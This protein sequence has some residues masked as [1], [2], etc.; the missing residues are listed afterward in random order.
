VARNL[1]LLR[2]WVADTPDDADAW[3]YLGAEYQMAGQ[4]GEAR[5]AYETGLA[6]AA[7][8]VET[9]LL[10][11]NLL[12]VLESLGQWDAV[13]E[14]AVSWQGDG[15]FYPDFWLIAGRAAMRTGRLSLAQE[16]FRRAAAFRPDRPLAFETA[17][18]R[19]WK[20][21]AYQAL[22]AAETGDWAFVRQALAPWRDVVGG[23][24]FLMRLYLHAGLAGPSAAEVVGELAVW[25]DKPL[26]VAVLDAVDEVLMRFPAIRQALVPA[27]EG[28]QGGRWL[29]ARQAQRSGDFQ[30]MLRVASGI[31]H[32]QAGGLLLQGLAWLGLQQA[33]E[34]VPLL[35]AACGLA[36]DLAEAWAARGE[37]AAALGDDEAWAHWEQ[38]MVA[39][40]P[41]G[42]VLAAMARRALATGDA[43][44]APK[45]LESLRQLD[46]LHP[47]LWP[48]GDL[49]RRV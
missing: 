5:T 30:A 31:V 40:A 21:A 26:T 12:G 19:T 46:P 27:V 16:W 25:L 39:G 38:A 28:L 10:R 18:A 35:S 43:A 24:P 20:P 22:L 15:D 44:R 41:A 42:P 14:R 34:A 17:G 2:R 29:I 13:L 47:L 8:V 45:L 11:V 1:T 6:A 4:L 32:P 3:Y 7:G 23:D 33:V 36:P 37:A 49:L 48:L 9:S